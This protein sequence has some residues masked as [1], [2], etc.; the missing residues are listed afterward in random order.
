MR[1]RELELLQ[2]LFSLGSVSAA[3]RAL[4]MSQPN[5]SKSLKKFEQRFGFALFERINGRL[6]P[7]AEARL[8]FDPV[9]RASLSLRSF[10]RLV[11][12]VRT[13][14][15]GRLNIGGLPLLSRVWLP[16][17]LARFMAAHPGVA[18]SFHTRSSKRLI[19]WVADRQID[20]AVSLLMLDDPMVDRSV[21]TSLEF[22]AAIPATHRLAAERE[23]DAAMLDGEPYISLG[24]LDRARESVDQQLAAAGAVP[25]ERAEC[26]LPAVAVQLVERNVGIAVID[27]VTAGEYHGQGVVF[28]PFRPAMSMQVW[29]LR[30]RMRPRSRIVDEFTETLHRK[31]EEER[32]GE[33]PATLFAAPPD[34]DGS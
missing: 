34:A 1:L 29:L 11:D 17:A 27:H 32:L 15:R 21:L 24:M 23:I 10:N 28:R 2:A 31:V 25:D 6:H 7:T 33:P 18:V 14:Q 5:A 20:L 3:A 26:S 4:H 30:P 16:D 19:E 22:V 12:D 8:L 13:M 9:E